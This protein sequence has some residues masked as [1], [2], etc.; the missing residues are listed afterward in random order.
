MG[1]LSELLVDEAIFT[2]KSL[3]IL[4]HLRNFLGLKLRKLCLLV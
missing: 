3:D 4:G 2:G 1:A